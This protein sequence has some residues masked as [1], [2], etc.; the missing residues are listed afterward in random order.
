MSRL[1]IILIASF[2]IL[3]VLLAL[4]VVRPLVIPVESGTV[5]RESTLQTEDE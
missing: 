4:V 5:F 2:V 3:G 1:R